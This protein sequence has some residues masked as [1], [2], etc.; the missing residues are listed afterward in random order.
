[1]EKIK[2]TTVANTEVVAKPQGSQTAEKTA[3]AEGKGIVATRILT[4]AGVIAALYV[5]LSLLTL[6]VA[7]GAIQFRASEALT[8]LPL[9]FPEAIPALAI[10]CM[11]SNIITGCAV[12]DVIFGSVITLVAAVLTFYTGKIIKTRWLKIGVG[13]LFPVLLNA[14]FLPVIWYYCYGEL[15]FVYM[16]QVLFLIISQSVSVYAIGAPLYLGVE[17]LRLKE[18]KAVL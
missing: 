4:R 2:E 10:G 5:A 13:G 6:P 7:S 12:W 18:F 8:I 3:K 11:L 17:R 16:L 14:F 1:M 15:E 9:F